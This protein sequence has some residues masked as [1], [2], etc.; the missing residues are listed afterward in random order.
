MTRTARG[1]RL[2][3]QPVPQFVM[4]ADAVAVL[5]DQNTSP[6][7]EAHPSSQPEATT[8]SRTASHPRAGTPSASSARAETH[9]TARRHASSL[10]IPARSPTPT[11]AGAS[12]RAGRTGRLH[13]YRGWCLS[14][15]GFPEP[16]QLLGQSVD[17]R[18]IGFLR[19]LS[20][21]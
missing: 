21:D 7:P 13:A 2:G 9:S 14:L 11:H 12:P 16:L 19:G 5:V 10:P 4:V 8:S 18:L 1:F 20:V 17:L 15:L 3:V 6:S